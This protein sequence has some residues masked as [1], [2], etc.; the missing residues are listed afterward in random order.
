MVVR[1]LEAYVFRCPVSTVVQTSFGAM[2][3]RPAVFV[4]IEDGDGSHGWGEAWCNFPSVGADYRARLLTNV[5]APM[6]IGRP[7]EDPAALFD[8][9]TQATAV[10]ALQTGERGP[11]A[12][13]IAAIDIAAWDLVARRAGEPLWRMFGGG[14]PEI[15][16]YASGINPTEPGLIANA[17]RAEGHRAFKLKVG[18]G[19]GRDQANLRTIRLV[20]GD[21]PLA[22][23]ANQA[24]SLPEAKDMLTVLEPFGLAWIEE[25]LRCD[26]PWHEWQELARSGNTPIA[27]GENLIGEI[28][29]A[30]AL[31]AEACGIVQPD[32]TKWG[33]FS[34][35]L[36]VARSILEAG[37]RF[38][39]HFLGAGV[40]LVAS[41]HLL[42][43]AGGDGLL[44]IDSNDNPLRDIIAAP[45]MAIM[46]GRVRL[47]D[48]AGLGIEPDLGAIEAFR[49]VLSSS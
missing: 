8:H 45:Q 42:A 39:P 37:R 49:V 10:L 36:P 12:Q 14:S 38:C 6:M 13:V 23:D 48:A 18:F 44:E 24:W 32:V 25:P 30:A 27:A 19:A 41:G 2:R 29:F 47:S 1:R 7:F 28:E 15:G 20:I 26:R 17:K 3:D 16:V 35:C 9:L 43:A 5:L 11:F 21:A 40:G 31:A 22:V 46:E 33:G 4:R 34:G